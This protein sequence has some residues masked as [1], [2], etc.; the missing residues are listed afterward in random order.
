MSES[1]AE[2]PP[3]LRPFYRWWG[4]A[5]VAR[6]EIDRTLGFVALG[7]A[8]LF[9]VATGIAMLVGNGLCM[10]LGGAMVPACIVW[11]AM[12]LLDRQELPLRLDAQGLVLRYQGRIRY[13]QVSL[14]GGVGESIR[15]AVLSEGGAWVEVYNGFPTPPWDV[16]GLYWFAAQLGKMGNVEVFSGDFDIEGWRAWTSDPTVRPKVKLERLL[17]D[18]RVEHAQLLVATPVEPE[19]VEFGMDGLR[20][21]DVELDQEELRA[22]RHALLDAVEEVAVVVGEQVTLYVRTATDLR[23]VLRRPRSP[24]DAAQVNWLAERVRQA[25]EAARAQDEGDHRDVPDAL[26]RLAVREKP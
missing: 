21:G 1:T 24:S 14:S 17:R 9:A 20:W 12:W 19:D 8:A 22:D 2:L 7:A 4:G 25:A 23:A 26:K 11:G 15:L 13:R 16:E 10:M 5:L 6:G 3:S 18:S